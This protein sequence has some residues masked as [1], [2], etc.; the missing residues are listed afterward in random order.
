MKIN[1]IVGLVIV[2]SL[3]ACDLTKKIDYDT[4]YNADKIVINGFISSDNG[5]DVIIKKT[6]APNS[7]DG[8]D[9]IDSPRISLICN[10]IEVAQ[11][12][13]SEGYKY[14]LAP[15]F[16]L[17]DDAVYKIK[18]EA[19]GLETVTSEGQ[20]LVS[21]TLVDKVYIVHDTINWANFIYIEFDDDP[22]KK[23]YYTYKIEYYKEGVIE[24][25]NKYF[26]PLW[27]F[28]D[29]GFSNHRVVKYERIS[30]LN[31]DSAK[32]SLYTVPEFYYN[33]IQSYSDYEI[34]NQNYYYETIYPV[35]TNIENGFGFFSSYEVDEYLYMNE[36]KKI[37]YE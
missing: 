22:N 19:S 32:V 33:F 7:P 30:S 8:N 18:V 25:I 23:N 35:M 20:E 34:S 37:Y 3:A 9:Y 28:T 36:Y 15:G 16:L 26:L 5:V 13:K 14:N 21:K 1:Q 11:L 17:T 29:E 10:E 2:I 6:V 12:V 4:L 31:F 24:S 27:A